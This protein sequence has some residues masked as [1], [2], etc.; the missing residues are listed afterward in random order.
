MDTQPEP[1]QF[2]E[3]HAVPEPASPTAGYSQPPGRPQQPGLMAAAPRPWR[4]G[5][6]FFVLLLLVLGGSLLMNVVMVTQQGGFE[7]DSTVQEKFVSHSRYA[8]DKV[9]IVPIDGVILEE[10]DS[11]VKKA[12]DRIRKDEHVKAVVLRV[13]SPGGS[14]SGSDYLLHHISEVAADRKIPVVVS[15]GTIAA[16]GG[17]YV[18]MAVG[19]QA[20]SI[21]A[22]PTT[23]TGSIGVIIPHYNAAKLLGDWGVTEDSVASHRLKG[24]GSFARDMTPEER[25]IFQELVDNSFSHFKDVVK[26]GRPRFR[27]DPKALDALATGQVY[28]AQQALKLGLVDRIGF[29]EDAVDRAIA[30]ANLNPDE[31]RVVKYRKEPTISDLLMGSQSRA[32]GFDVKALLDSAAPKAYYLFGRSP[33]MIQGNR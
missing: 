15:M 27:K 17:Y 19:D 12:M 23:W 5:R 16:S 10:T 7:Y 22:E 18:S 21:Y 1:N 24:M 4:W 25:K 11:V 28:D 2:A 3:V 20:D 30:L 33:L 32:A 13:D 26:Q 9:A 8:S 29:L 14:V 31:V 6:L